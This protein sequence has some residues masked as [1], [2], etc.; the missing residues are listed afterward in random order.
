MGTTSIGIDIFLS[1]IG[2]TQEVGRHVGVVFV[3]STTLVDT[4]GKKDEILS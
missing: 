4:V 3:E 2:E 1:V